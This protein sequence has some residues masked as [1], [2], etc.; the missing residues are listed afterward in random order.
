VILDTGVLLAAAVR[1]D[2]NHDAARS[3][4]GSPDLKLIPEPVVVETCYMLASRL[5]PVVEAAFVRS[6]L[7]RTFTVE[8]M[9]RE[10]RERVVDLL[11]TYADNR[12]GY[13]DAAIVA[14]AERVGESTIATLDRRDFTA[15]RPRHVDAFTLIPWASA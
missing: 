12:L 1:T 13:V 7:G 3:I 6:L 5:G 4:L 8:Q 11:T 2:R 15:V 14:V 10:D 9:T